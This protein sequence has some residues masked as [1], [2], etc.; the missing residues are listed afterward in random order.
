M[1]SK[2]Y[3]T[4]GIFLH[5]KSFHYLTERSMC[6]CTLCPGMTT[7]AR[8]DYLRK[9]IKKHHSSLPKPSSQHF[10]LPLSPFPSPSPSPSNS[11]ESPITHNLSPPI[12]P[13][14]SNSHSQSSQSSSNS[15]SHNSQNVC[16]C[17]RTVAQRLALR[18][19]SIDNFPRKHVDSILN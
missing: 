5:F 8:L 9:H 14:S 6:Q 18:L 12:T 16:K 1:C 19:H 17:M 3:S 4:S 10:V 13:Q 15:H 11:I 7:F 2:N